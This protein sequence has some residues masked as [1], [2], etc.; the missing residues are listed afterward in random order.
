MCVRVCVRVGQT[1]FFNLNAAFF[2]KQLERENEL[3]SRLK[4]ISD[5]V[6]YGTEFIAL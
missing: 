6:P 2:K 4:N 3:V 5:G 1:L